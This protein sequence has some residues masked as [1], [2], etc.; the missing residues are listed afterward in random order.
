MKATSS[1]S[2]GSNISGAIQWTLPPQ[3]KLAVMLKEEPIIWVKPKSEIRACPSSEM[4]T[5]TFKY[6]RVNLNFDKATYAL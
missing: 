3:G 2:G 6:V 5:L 4:S 1:W